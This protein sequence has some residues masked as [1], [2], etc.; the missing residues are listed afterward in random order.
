[1]KSIAAIFMLIF[2]C[3]PACKNTVYVEKQ[4]ENVSRTVYA[5]KDSLDKA[6]IDL[7]SRYINETTKLIVPPKNR[8]QIEAI[9]VPVLKPQTTKNVKSL[10]KIEEKKRVVIIPPQFANEEVIVVGSEEYDNLIIAKE[11]ADQ[12]AKDKINL[13]KEI[14]LT[15]KTLRSN[16]ES[17]AKMTAD[18]NTL[19]V[20]IEQK[21]S[22]I[23]K[24]I[25]ILVATIG[26]IGVYV[27]LKV[28]YLLPSFLMF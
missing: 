3:M 4:T 9:Y 10:P 1:M 11:I 19:N 20:K 21:N 18:V 15:D 8:I 26:L 6:R 23:F 5:T 25:T 22:L 7:A 28:K 16:Q 17:I 13:E 27:Y 24:L 2:F 14:Q 12:L